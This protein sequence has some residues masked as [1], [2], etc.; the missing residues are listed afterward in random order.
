MNRA[1]V[2]MFL[3]LLVAGCPKRIDFGPGGEIT[4]PDVLLAQVAE[5]E[6][7]AVTVKG[8]AKLKVR[9]PQAS[10]AVTLF[11]ASSRPA[12]LHLET[13]DFFG[14]P[15]A[16]LVADGQRFGLYAAEENRFYRGPAS[17]ANVSRFLPVMLPGEELVALLLGQAPRI[18][19]ER[20]ALAV[21]RDRGVYVLTLTRG[22]VEQ[23]LEVHPRYLRVTRSQVRGVRAYD[24]AFGDFAV[25][26]AGAFPREVVLD[27][28]SADTRLELHYTDV[29][30]NAAPDLTLFE[31][32]PPEGVP[33][34]EVDEAGREQPAAPGS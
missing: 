3:G 6:A 22:Q 31:L 29:S 5:A 12:L 2:T 11:V 8:E 23:R 21:D 19:A 9:S 16:V 7:R 26:P 27:A 10:G 25:T 14:R 24:A 4:D 30:L 20:K 28:A 34:V 1:L 15:Q 18:P 32:S 13:L 17:P 33:V